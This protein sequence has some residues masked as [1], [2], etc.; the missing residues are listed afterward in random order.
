MVFLGA[1]SFIFEWSGRTCEVHPFTNTL[2]SVKNVP[3]VDSLITYDCPCTHHTYVLLC[4]NSIY[5]QSIQNKLFPP[6]VMQKSGA[7]LN[8]VAKINCPDPTVDY[9]STYFVSNDLQTTLN[10][11]GTFSYFHSR[12]ATKNELSS[13]DKI[14]ITTDAQQWNPYCTS[15][16]LDKRSMLSYAGELSNPEQRQFLPI[17]HAFEDLDVD[18]VTV[19]SVNAEIYK[20]MGNSYLA[21][22]CALTSCYDSSF[23]H[24]LNQ[25]V[26]ISKMMSSIGNTTV[27]ESDFPLF[28]DPVSAPF[29]SLES[30]I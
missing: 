6:F 8:D 10:L 21:L 27:D 12:R 22:S 23:F 28:Y 16:E 29:E 5:V 13:C 20:R 17:N 14:L 15:F 2:E 11:N 30:Q 24:T 19:A 1:D 3:I 25:R 18:S 4:Q 26:E 9:H 7:T